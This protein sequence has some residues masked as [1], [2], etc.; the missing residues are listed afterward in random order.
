MCDQVSGVSGLLHN[1]MQELELARSAYSKTLAVTDGAAAL[2]G[3]D[4]DDLIGSLANAAIEAGLDVGTVKAA[5]EAGKSRANWAR[6]YREST[7]PPKPAPRAAPEADEAPT[8]P[9]ASKGVASPSLCEAL[10]IQA[11][12][13]DWEISAREAVS[14][15]NEAA[16]VPPKT[17]T[18]TIEFDEPSPTKLRLRELWLAAMAVRA[19]GDR[20]KLQ[21]QFLEHARKSGLVKAASEH[22]A[23]K[24]QPRH[25]GEEDVAHIISWGLR[26]MDPWCPGE[27]PNG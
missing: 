26:G 5:V 8:R 16:A 27:F 4:R 18:T 12:E 20:A 15:L 10:R 3:Y 14:H 24:N 25:W 21:Q 13:R 17:P 11:Q 2:V 6:Q 23:A 1:A 22:Y 7:P 19:K 9:G